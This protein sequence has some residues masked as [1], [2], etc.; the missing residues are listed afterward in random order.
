MRSRI[1]AIV[2]IVPLGLL[3]AVGTA[4]AGMLEHSPGGQDKPLIQFHRQLSIGGGATFQKYREKHNGNTLDKESG[5]MPN[6]QVSGSWMFDNHLFLELGDQYS[7]G[8]T[9]YQS[10]T[11]QTGHTNNDIENIHLRI[12]EGFS[13]SKKVMVTPYMT[14]G[15]RYWNRHLGGPAPYAEDYNTNYIGVGVMADYRATQRL[16]LSGDVMGGSTFANGMTSHLGEAQAGLSSPHFD[17]GSKP[18]VKVSLKSD[19]RV[20]GPWHLYGKVTYTHFSYGHSGQKTVYQNGAAVGNG[21]EPNST[22]NDVGM[23]AGV[24]YTF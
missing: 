12:G 10:A 19:Y 7:F 8:K 9:D 15:H 21:Y 24:R 5:W 14:Y 4:Q 17:L 20:R 18:I 13:L 23:D 3:G 1:P 6:I 11:G 16:T 2:A 22:T